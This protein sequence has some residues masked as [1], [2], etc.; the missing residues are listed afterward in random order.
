MRHFPRDYCVAAVF[1]FIINSP[2]GV[3]LRLQAMALDIECGKILAASW[4]RAMLRRCRRP[5]DYAARFVSLQKAGDEFHKTTDKFSLMTTMTPSS[6]TKAFWR[7]KRYTAMKAV[8][9]FIHRAEILKPPRAAIIKAI[10]RKFRA[11][12][13]AGYDLTRHADALAG[14]YF[15]L[16]K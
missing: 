8:S 2:H 7:R 10:S 6:Y 4:C 1:Y 12:H 16:R 15:D 9:V 13:F 11:N 3:S 14:Y 5:F